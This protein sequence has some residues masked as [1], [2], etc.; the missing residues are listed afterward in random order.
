MWRCAPTARSA[1]G[2]LTLIEL[3]IV[4]TLLSIFFGSI[5]EVVIAGLRV[6]NASDEREGIRQQLVTA[7]D[8][9]TREVGLAS[10]V[11][12]AEDQRVQFDAD[13]DGNGTVE[14]DVT[15]QVQGGDLQ[16]VY[17]GVTVT[18]VR[19][20]TSLDFDYVDL[21]QGALTPPLSGCSLDTLR[22]IQM[23]MTA[24]NDQETLSVAA[25]AF[26]RNND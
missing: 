24:T 19:D 3:L 18:L 17:N 11:D 22:V 14:S 9:L 23:A 4:V 25:G 5:Y 12:V 7:L 10:N 2:G 26:L 15:Y 6:A 21:N 13:L 16:R 20:L 8:R 1:N